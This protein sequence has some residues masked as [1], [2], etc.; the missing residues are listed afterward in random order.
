VDD[1]LTSARDAVA[2]AAGISPDQLTLDEAEARELL[3]VARIAAHTSGDRTNA[4]LLSY[5]VGLAVANGGDL[6][7]VVSA[8]RTL[9]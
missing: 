7:A 5:L 3:D 6:E 4:P 2:A 9:R 8:V 1:W